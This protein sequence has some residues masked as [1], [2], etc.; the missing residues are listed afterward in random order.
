MVDMSNYALPVNITGFDSAM[1]Y[2]STVF[3]QGT[4]YD[5]TGGLLIL[6]IF[7]GFTIIGAKYTQE[8]AFA[9]S[10]FMT[11]IAAFIMVSGGFLAPEFLMLCIIGFVM[12]VFL[13]RSGG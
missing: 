4:G 2:T 8:R 11:T 5:F 9:F 13:L 10:T 12:A 3:I 7:I 1:N 6:S